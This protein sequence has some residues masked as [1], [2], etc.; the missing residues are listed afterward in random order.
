M[1]KT[2][3]LA[4]L[5]LG[6]TYNEEDRLMEKEAVEFLDSIKTDADRIFL[7]GDVLDYWFEYKSVVPKGY[8]RFLGKLA[9]LADSGV[10][11]TWVIGNHDIWIFDYIPT[12]L[13]ISVIDGILEKNV[14]GVRFSIQH[15]D[16]IGGN[17]KFRF[18]RSF[19]RNR[20]CQWLFAGIHPGWTVDFAFNWSHRSRESG[21]RAKNYKNVDIQPIREWC[22]NRI[23]GGDKAEYFV[24][25]HFHQEEREELPEGRQMI[26]LP[27]WLEDKGYG[28]FDGKD[29]RIEYYPGNGGY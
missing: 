6:A 25:G 10:K 9:E 27:A 5:H 16:A 15:G 29:F 17:F 8:V 22:I 23:K 20:F 28:V 7:L 21:K 19:F 14:E 3:F 12:E 2:Y 24:F 4:D 26:M 11:I 13:G 18:L 1:G